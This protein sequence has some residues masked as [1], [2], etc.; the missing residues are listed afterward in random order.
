[1][2]LASG[3]FCQGVWLDLTANSLIWAVFDIVSLL[4]ALEAPYLADV[5]LPNG[6]KNIVSSLA[7]SFDTFM[8]SLTVTAMTMVSIL[9]MKVV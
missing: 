1:M 6:F 7:M 2:K 4:L 9:F 3:S 5:L 8:S